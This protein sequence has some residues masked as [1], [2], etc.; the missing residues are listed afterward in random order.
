MS[1]SFGLFFF[2]FLSVNQDGY[3]FIVEERLYL[4]YSIISQRIRK[5]AYELGW[6]LLA[7]IEGTSIDLDKVIGVSISGRIGIEQE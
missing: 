5:G 4:L 2:F 3:L 1:V 6:I 7:G